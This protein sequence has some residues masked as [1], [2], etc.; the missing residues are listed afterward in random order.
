MGDNSSA[1]KWHHLDAFL[2][3]GHI[4]SFSCLLIIISQI[5]LYISDIIL[6]TSVAEIDA[7]LSA[8][9]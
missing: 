6:Q 3:G 9:T 4:H 5:K 1:D 2:V 7:F 8:Q